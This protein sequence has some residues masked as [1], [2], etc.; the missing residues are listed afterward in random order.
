MPSSAPRGL[1]V[2]AKGPLAALN[3]SRVTSGMATISAPAERV[4][5]DLQT[6][7]GTPKAA[8]RRWGDLVV[9]K[10]R[11]RDPTSA[12]PSAVHSEGHPT[13]SEPQRRL[14]TLRG[15]FSRILG[16]SRS[17]VHGAKAPVSS[18]SVKELE[19]PLLPCKHPLPELINSVALKG[20]HLPARRRRLPSSPGNHLLSPPL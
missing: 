10:H 16:G 17:R 13:P 6:H 15:F 2:P 14:S 20:R 5:G 12:G 11:R 9:R 4:M 19:P 7:V 3:H 18:D 8:A 1:K